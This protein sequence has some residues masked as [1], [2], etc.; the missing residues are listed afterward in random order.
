[1]LRY[2]VVGVRGYARALIDGIRTNGAELGCEL[3]AVTIR[4]KRRKAE[5][6]E[7][8]TKAGVEIFDDAPEMFERLAG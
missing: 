4:P 1:M 5:E 6:V 2:A 7:Q 3:V 8:F